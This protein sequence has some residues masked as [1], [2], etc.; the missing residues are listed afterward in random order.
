MTKKIAIKRKSENNSDGFLSEIGRPTWLPRHYNTK[1]LDL[2][3][4]EM[5]SKVLNY[6]NGNARN[7]TGQN[8][9]IEV[10]IFF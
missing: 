8:V 7:N 1:S 3:K 4:K 9:S 10:E 2:T 5:N 6:S